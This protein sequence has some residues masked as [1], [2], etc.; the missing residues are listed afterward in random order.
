[1]SHT[2]PNLYN[3]LSEIFSRRLSELRI[4][5]TL[6]PQSDELQD[7]QEL[8]FYIKFDTRMYLLSNDV[9]L[10]E[11]WEKVRS[12][13]ARVDFLM[14]CCSDLLCQVDSE[15]LSTY[16]TSLTGA[17]TGRGVLNSAIDED[18][19]Q[20]FPKERWVS[21]ILEQNTWLVVLYT[22]DQLPLP[23]ELIDGR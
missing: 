8:F 12:S 20:R 7:V 11:L 21:P 13:E 23:E 15:T 17:L 16:L 5:A 9:L 19:R 18:T 1:M 22:M 6:N 10:Q 14:N 2:N 4:K 3:A